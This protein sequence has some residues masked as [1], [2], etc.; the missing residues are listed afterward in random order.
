MNRHKTGFW[1]AF[2]L[3]ITVVGMSLLPGGRAL[4]DSGGSGGAPTLEELLETRIGSAARRLQA[5]LVGLETVK[6]PAART[7]VLARFVV[8]DG[9]PGAQRA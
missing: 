1:S 7:E 2:G 3:A 4:A 6:R 9:R 8:E 5:E